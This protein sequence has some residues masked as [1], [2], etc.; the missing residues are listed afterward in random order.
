[1]KLEPTEAQRKA[2]IGFLSRPYPHYDPYKPDYEGWLDAFL[3]AANSIPEGPPVGTIAR[4]PDGAW[5]AFVEPAQ[6]GV[7]LYRQLLAAGQGVP[8]GRDA[9]SWP[10]IFTPGEAVGSGPTT[11]G[12]ETYDPREPSREELREY[13]HK[14]LAEHCQADDSDEYHE[15]DKPRLERLMREPSVFDGD[16]DEVEELAKWLYIH[17]GTWPEDEWELRSKP[18]YYHDRAR[19]LL[20]FGYRKV[21]DPT[22]QQEP[23]YTVAAA[24]E[25]MAKYWDNSIVTTTK[26][27]PRVVD[28]LGVDERGSRWRNRAY[29]EFWF[30]DECW[31][32]RTKDGCTSWFTAGYEPKMCIFTEILEPR[33]LPS[34]DCEEARDGTVWE[35]PDGWRFWCENEDWRTDEGHS[36]QNYPLYNLRCL[37]EFRSYTEVLDVG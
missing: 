29:T 36:R 21:S 20:D 14:D 11:D 15:G 13:F 31:N 18:N 30:Q 24:S 10:V 5:I 16:A 26:R 33:V 35:E 9:D 2:I 23:A 4:R 28:R 34:L 7:W 3:A 37:T 12:G 6:P 1:M 27:E 25:E 32:F 19:E 17:I 8:E 22:A